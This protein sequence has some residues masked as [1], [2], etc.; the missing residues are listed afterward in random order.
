MKR[1]Q[2]DS[3]K[4]KH[5]NLRNSLRKITHQV[6]QQKY[7]LTSFQTISRVK[8]FVENVHHYNLKT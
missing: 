5:L 4:V 2:G 1:H 7:L 3:I 6:A 8:N